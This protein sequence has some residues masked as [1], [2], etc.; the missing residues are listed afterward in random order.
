[1]KGKGKKEQAKLL[2]ILRL[3]RLSPRC[4]PC[5]D[6]NSNKPSVKDVYEITRKLRT[7]WIQGNVE[8]SFLFIFLGVII[9]AK[10]ERK[11]SFSLIC[12]LKYL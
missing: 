5:L 2:Q 10:G 8:E 1:M 12:I 3:T 7:K 6:P 11:K 9:G 4:D